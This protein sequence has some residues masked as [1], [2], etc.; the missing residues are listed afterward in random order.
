MNEMA[1]SYRT[2]ILQNERP[3]ICL[4]AVLQLEQK[5]RDEIVAQMQKNKD[6]RK[7]TQ[8]VSNPC[9]G[10]IFRNPLPEHA[11]RLVED[12]G[13]K[14]HQIGGRKGFRDARQ[15]HRQRRRATAQDVLDLI[16]FIQKTIKARYR[17]AY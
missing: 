13:L 9:A 15:F 3:G 2:S 16:A 4:E 5:E 10:S 6:Y 1:F 17:H 8:P 7:E 14:G 11:G 12:A